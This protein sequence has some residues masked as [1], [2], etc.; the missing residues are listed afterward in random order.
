MVNHKQSMLMLI[1][2]VGVSFF[3]LAMPTTAE[4]AI[5]LR[6]CGGKRIVALSMKGAC[7]R[8]P[9][10]KL[11]QCRKVCTKRKMRIIC[12]RKEWRQTSYKLCPAKPSKTCGNKTVTV[13]LRNTGGRSIFFHGGYIKAVGTIYLL[14]NKVT[15]PAPRYDTKTGKFLSTLVKP[16]ETKTVNM[17]YTT[18]LGCHIKRR[19]KLIFDC[20]WK[21]QGKKWS[22]LKRTFSGKTA[23]NSFHFGTVTFSKKRCGGYIDATNHNV[24]NLLRKLLPSSMR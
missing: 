1:V 2:L 20:K 17:T 24:R 23:R 10:K 21:G 12:V 9:L 3:S 19:M 13:T 6:H 8:Y 22:A 14:K 4:A 11:V 15:P 18:R 16:G 5:F 7:R